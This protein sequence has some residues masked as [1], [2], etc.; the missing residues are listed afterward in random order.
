MIEELSTK[1]VLSRIRTKYNKYRNEDGKEEFANGI[2]YA[3]DLIEEMQMTPI[4]RTIKMLENEK[5]CVER[6]NSC[7]RACEKCELVKD[8]NKI[9]QAYNEAI[10]ALKHYAKIKAIVSRW[11]SDYYAKESRSDYFLE[12]IQTFEDEE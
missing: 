12:I 2:K 7:D 10:C 8:T 1:M 4:D 9:I 11:S 6:A 5:A 3:M